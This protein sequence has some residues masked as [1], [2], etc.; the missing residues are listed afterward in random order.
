MKGLVMK[1]VDKNL[2]SFQFFSQADK[3]VVL[4]DWPWA[5][6]GNTLML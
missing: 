6:D 1:D 5:F 3:E 4:N 2:F